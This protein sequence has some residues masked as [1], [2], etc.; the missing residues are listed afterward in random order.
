MAKPKI[1]VID[2][3]KKKR[4]ALQNFFSKE[5]YMVKIVDNGAVAKNVLKKEDF[6]LILCDWAMPEVYCH[7]VIQDLNKLK[8]RPK[9]GIITCWDGKL[10]S[11]KNGDMDV[12]FI[13]RKP[14]D[15]SRLLRQ[16]SEVVNPGQY[17]ST[18]PPGLMTPD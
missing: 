14:F 7:N 17:T 4:G 5:G 3:E 12:D 9:I 10:M 6:D 18:N 16:I 11:I 8:K 1:M 15:L 2:G 13:A